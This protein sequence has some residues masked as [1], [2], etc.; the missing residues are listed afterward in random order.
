[1]GGERCWRTEEAAADGPQLGQ[2]GVLWP[3]FQQLVQP[4][5]DALHRRPQQRRLRH[6]RALDVDCHA[7]V[8]HATPPMSLFE[9]QLCL[10]SP[11]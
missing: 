1:M 5:R 2:D 3:V 7:C 11:T 6:R 10:W 8:Q 9:G 4:L